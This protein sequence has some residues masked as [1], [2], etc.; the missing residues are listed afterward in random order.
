MVHNNYN[1]TLPQL[2]LII[3]VVVRFNNNNNTYQYY[4]FFALELEQRAA[5]TLE[6]YRLPGQRRSQRQT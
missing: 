5:V 6:I 1:I 4:S 3:I 2:H